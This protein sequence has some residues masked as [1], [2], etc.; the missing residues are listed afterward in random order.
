MIVLAAGLPES[1]TQCYIDI[2]RRRRYSL[3]I[4]VTRQKSK[5]SAEAMTSG[6][7]ATSFSIESPV[8]TH[9]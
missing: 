6:T 3:F 8:D 9:F 5:E 4:Y 1:I 7:L 2:Y